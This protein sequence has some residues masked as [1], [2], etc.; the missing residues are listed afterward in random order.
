M[1]AL[2]RLAGKRVTV[3]DYPDGRIKIRYEGRDL[4]YR[5]FDRLTHTH[6]GKWSAISAARKNVASNALLVVTPL[7]HP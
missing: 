5:E 6:Q 1:A 2:R 7:R 4:A 3:L